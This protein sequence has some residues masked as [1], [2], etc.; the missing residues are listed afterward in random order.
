MSDHMSK[1]WWRTIH[2]TWENLCKCRELLLF[3]VKGPG[4][5][6]YFWI[7]ENFDINVQLWSIFH[8]FLYGQTKSGEVI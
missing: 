3:Q 2:E 8:A 1:N 6:E 4:G 5:S 7:C